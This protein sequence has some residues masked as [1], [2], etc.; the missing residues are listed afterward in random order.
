MALKRR[1]PDLGD[2]VSFESVLTI[3]TVL[4]VLRMVFL[5]PMVNLDKAKTESARRDRT[6]DLTARRVA[7]STS[8]TDEAA[9]YAVAMGLSQA[10]TRVSPPSRGASVWIESVLPDSSLVVVRHDRTAGTYV[11]LHAQSRSELPSCQ[12]GR[13]EWSAPERQ[14]FTV[15]DSVDYGDRGVGELTLREY[16]HWLEETDR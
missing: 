13:L 9:P 1:G 11:R 6:W 15:S 16:R 8:T 4:L 5:V 7:S 12:Y 14:W 3:F 2:A 10:R